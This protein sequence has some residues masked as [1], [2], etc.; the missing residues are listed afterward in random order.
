[1]KIEFIKMKLK[2]ALAILAMIFYANI[3]NAQTVSIT[4]SASGAVCSGTNVIFNAI[5][6]G[7]SNPY[8]Q[9]Y[10]NGTAITAAITLCI[11]FDISFNPINLFF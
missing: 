7:F 3:T 1:M 4:S 8:Y 11:K 2:I 6:T 10:E 5:A 9:W